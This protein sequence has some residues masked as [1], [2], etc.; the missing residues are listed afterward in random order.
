L[1]QVSRFRKTPRQVAYIVPGCCKAVAYIHSKHVLHRDLHAKNFLVAGDRPKNAVWL[2]DF[3]VSCFIAK[4]VDEA[5]PPLNL[6]G[7]VCIFRMRAPEIALAGQWKGQHW[8]PPERAKYSYPSDVWSLA[9]LLWHM[10]S[11]HP[12]FIGED[13]LPYTYDFVAKLGPIPQIALEALLA[14]EGSEFFESPLW[15][16]SQAKQWHSELSCHSVWSASS[17]LYWLAVLRSRGV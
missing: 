15:L 10:C 12:P 9:V 8:V 3:G 17:F 5:A 13:T 4:D 2:S 1:E 6:S 11:G 14:G 7:H 16:R